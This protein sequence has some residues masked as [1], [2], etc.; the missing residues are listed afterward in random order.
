MVGQIL[1]GLSGFILTTMANRALYIL[2]LSIGM[3]FPAWAET[4]SE[5]P[6]DSAPSEPLV[7][8]VPAT[9]QAPQPAEQ[10]IAR[11]PET[12]DLPEN[13]L[14]Y[15]KKQKIPLEEI[16]L[17][18]QDVNADKPLLLHD[19]DT[20]R[21][22]A[23]TMKLLTTWSALKVLGPSASWDTEAWMRGSLENGVLNGDLILKGYGDPFLVYE[24]FWQFVHDLRLKGLREITG[25]III[26]NSFFSIPATD[27]AAFDGEPDRVYNAP[28]SALMFNFQAT[29]LLL[30]PD[31]AQGKV[32]ITAFPMPKG[33][34]LDN[35]VKLIKGGCSKWQTRPNI[36]KLPDGV[37]R[38]KGDYSEACG[39]QFA[40]MVMT[41]PEEHVFNAFHDFWLMLGGT[42]H[43]GYK[44]GSVQASDQRL[45]VHTSPAVG[46][47][48]RLINKWSNNVM[49]RQLLLSVGAKMFGAPATLEKGR[50]ATLKVMTDASIPTDGMVID[51]G[52]G[53]SRSTRI[54]A[55]QLGLLLQAIWR[56][57]Y[58]PEMLNSLPLLGEDGT[59]ARRFRHSDLTGRSRMKTG[60]L[61]QVSA[62]AGY[63][64]TRSGKRVVIVMQHNGKKAGGY[65]QALQNMLL[66]WVFEQ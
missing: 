15:M 45:E 1:L 14:A 49:T 32:N 13:L 65:G 9:Y 63:M 22:P 50:L 34:T 12:Q 17:F 27:P 56:D 62:L 11:S 29:R 25:D 6:P 66:E 16:S 41:S 51:N 10:F 3:V 47:Q 37:I 57:P 35:Q 33:A 24:S 48:V 2:I 52:A 58:M 18:V 30:D 61:N 43:G 26:D 54:S 36:T 31:T 20:P 39:Q 5:E 38:V 59:L 23:S 4:A 21:N 55:R 8:S 44:V 28:P 7:P 19:A 64:L 40:M 53:L 42:L 60:T 46:E